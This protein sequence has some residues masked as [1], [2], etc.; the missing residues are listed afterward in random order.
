VST[1]RAEKRR[2][3]EREGKKKECF[4]DDD[5]VSTYVCIGCVVETPGYY[6]Y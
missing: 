4:W 3:R 2:E 5:D 6:Y 1:H